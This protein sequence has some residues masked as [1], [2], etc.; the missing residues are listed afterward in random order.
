MRVFVK[1]DKVMELLQSGEWELGY[2]GGIR[3]DGTYQLQQGGLSKGGKTLGVRA[4]TVTALLKRKLIEVEPK[5]EKQ[6][7]WM[8]RYRLTSNQPDSREG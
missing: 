4:G 2:F 3:N 8:R 6:P 1:L 5:R 7:Y